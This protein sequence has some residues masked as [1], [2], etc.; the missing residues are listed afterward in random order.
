MPWG[1]QHGVGGCGWVCSSCLHYLVVHSD[2]KAVDLASNFS[3]PGIWQ[4]G[5]GE[6]NK[7]G[8]FLP[9]KCHGG[10]KCLVPCSPG[11]LLGCSWWPQPVLEQPMFLSFVLKQELL[12]TCGS[13]PRHRWKCAAFSWSL[14]STLHLCFAQIP[15]QLLPVCSPCPTSLPVWTKE[16][17]AGP[18]VVSTQ[19]LVQQ[20]W[21]VQGGAFI[22]LLLLL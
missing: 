20:G 14:P 7:Q 10:T 3:V 9:W 6:G 16:Q 22:L 15:P 19:C 11:C 17:P 1:L 13:T 18:G 2:L 21:G 5:K 4:D 12:V 8:S